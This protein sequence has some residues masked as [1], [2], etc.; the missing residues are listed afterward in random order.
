M[1]TLSDL[2][3]L[4]RLRKITVDLEDSDIHD[5]STLEKLGS[6]EELNLNLRGTYIK[7]LPNLQPLSN[8][9]TVTADI[10]HSSVQLQQT[11]RLSK[12]QDL[13]VDTGLASLRDLP[14]TVK[15]LSFVQ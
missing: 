6:L 3:F 5:L 1:T 11:D 15:R 4:P 10:S 9:Q 7:I 2:S 12:L 13:T 14:K 8:L